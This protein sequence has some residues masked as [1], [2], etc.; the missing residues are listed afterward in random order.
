MQLVEKRSHFL[1]SQLFWQLHHDHGPTG[2]HVLLTPKSRLA[3]SRFEGSADCSFCHKHYFHFQYSHLLTQAQ[4]RAARPLPPDR[5]HVS[6]LWESSYFPAFA[7]APET[8]A[9]LFRSNAH[10]PSLTPLP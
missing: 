3:S 8:R 6:P 4:T 2:R 7:R 5:V 1:P 10:T 9:G